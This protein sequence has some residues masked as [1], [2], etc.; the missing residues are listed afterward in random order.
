MYKFFSFAFL[1]LISFSVSFAQPNLDKPSPRNQ[2]AVAFDS[3]RGKLVLFGGIDQTGKSLNDTWEWDGSKWETRSP[4]TSPPAR[5]AHAVIYDA[6]RGR[7]VLF[8]GQIGPNALSDTWEWDGTTWTQIRSKNSPPGRVAHALVYDAKNKRTILFGGTDFTT[9]QI[10]NDTWAWDGRDWTRIDTKSSPEGRF[11]AT[12]AFDSARDKI[13]LFGGNAA[14]PPL[15]SAKFK[16]G[17]RNDTW[18]FDGQGLE[19]GIDSSFACGARSSLD[20]V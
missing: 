3:K 17:Q 16:A 4:A 9:S 7:V 19:A 18:E 1:F 10:F 5:A 12:M 11:H 6:K 2:P 13:V 15:N 14:V 8:G 20:G